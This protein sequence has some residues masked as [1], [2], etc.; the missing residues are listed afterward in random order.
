VVKAKNKIDQPQGRFSSE[1]RI[2]VLK[3]LG[4]NRSTMKPKPYIV[5][6]KREIDL[7]DPWQKKWYIQQVL[8]HGKAEDVAQLDWLEI[9]GC[10]P[11]LDLPVHIRHLWEDHF[12]T[13]GQVFRFSIFPRRTERL[14]N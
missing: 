10:L 6:S 3:D 13:W 5:W 11:E 2:A 1:L 9:R 12:S 7:S 4:Y 8:I 14:F